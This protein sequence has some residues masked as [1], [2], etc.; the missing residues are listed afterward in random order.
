MKNKIYITFFTV[1]IALFAVSCDDFLGETPDNRTEIDTPEK[2]KQLLV[3]AYPATSPAYIG[4]MSSDNTDENGYGTFEYDPQQREFYEWR[5]SVSNDG[6][7]PYA[8]WANCYGAIVSANVALQ[9]IER[10]GDTQQLAPMKGEALLCRAYA[11]FLLVNTFC[12]HYGANS[13]TDLGVPYATEP[14][15][16]VNPQYERGTVADV[17]RKIKADIEEGLPLIDDNLYTVPKFHFNRKA[18]YAFATR[19]YLYMCDYNKAIECANAV[20]SESPVLTDWRTLGTL[21][22]N[23]NDQPNFFISQSNPAT[24]M[25]IGAFSFWPIMHGPYVAGRRYGHGI[26]IYST[27][28]TG[29]NTP[30]GNMT[31]IIRHIPFYNPELPRYV[32]RKLGAYVELVDPMAGTGIY[33]MM[34]PAF[35]SDE[36]LLCRAEAYIMTKN[37]DAAVKDMNLFMTEFTTSRSD[38]TR[39]AIGN[40]YGQMPY[41]TLNAPTPKKK[42]NPDFTVEEGEQE[43]LIHAALHLRRMLTLH[44]GLRWFDVKRYGIEILRRNINANNSM[45]ETDVLQK[46]D[47]RRAVQLPEGVTSAGMTPNPR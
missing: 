32:H 26:A 36:T 43:N 33:H 23:G 37:Y 16:T 44:E 39:T 45:S 28:T 13:E 46:N 3:T 21:P 25:T 42:L 1:L 7:S 11:H 5:E 15:T 29:S 24:L 2:V 34:Y 38:I 19:F 20:L 47:P 27:E 10:L 9:A 40:F 18:A 30:W 35:I 4:E 17:Y 8:L 41:Y 6:D 14:E 12:Q 31:S 22:V